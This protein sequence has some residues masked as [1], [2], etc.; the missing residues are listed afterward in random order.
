M[1]TGLSGSRTR[2][3]I[4]ALARTTPHAAKARTVCVWLPLSK[5][6][7]KVCTLSVTSTRMNAVGTRLAG[8]REPVGT[9]VTAAGKAHTYKTSG[10]R[11]IAGV[12][13]LGRILAWSG[14]RTDAA[15]EGGPS[16]EALVT[17]G[18]ALGVHQQ[19][20]RARGT[21]S[22]GGVLRCLAVEPEIAHVHAKGS[23]A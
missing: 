12:T 5:P 6:E 13:V 14:C 4:G 8:A 21:S 11:V 1:V 22:V 15:V 19:I 10:R 23:R 9:P 17:G 3:G 7:K 2:I 18:A 16:H 20:H